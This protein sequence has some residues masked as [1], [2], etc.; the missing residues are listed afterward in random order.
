MSF[1]LLKRI[2]YIY[3]SRGDN[4]DKNLIERINYLARKKKTVGLTAKEQVEQNELR[5]EYKFTNYD[6]Y[7]KTSKLNSEDFNKLNND[8]IDSI[9]KAFI[10]IASGDFKIN[11]K[12]IN[13]NNV[14]CSYCKFKDVCYFK[15][16]DYVDIVLEKEDL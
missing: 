1:N 2:Y 12:R 7:S 11:P 13:N 16:S 14:T 6:I 10:T 5:D 4:N 15:E 3:Y 9:N 8:V